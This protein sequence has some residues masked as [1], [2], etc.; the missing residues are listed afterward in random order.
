[1]LHSLGKS[2]ILIVTPMKASALKYFIVSLLASLVSIIIILMPFHALLTVY[3]SSL[4]GHYTLLRLW[5]EMLL[6][7]C[8]VGCLYLL[9]A[10][11]KVRSHTLTRR[12]IWVIGGYGLWLGVRVLLALLSHDVTHKA[13]AYGLLIDL[14]FLAFF[15]VAWTVALRTVQL[16]AQWQRLLLWP[17]Y[18]VVGFALLQ[19]LVL[20]PDFLRHFGYD[21]ATTISPLETINHNKQ[22]V[23]VAS[24]LRGANPL[25]AYLLLPISLLMVYVVTPAKRNRSHWLVLVAALAA[26]FF[27]FS[28]SAWLGAV[29]SIVV[30]LYVRFRQ[31]LT[32]KLLPIAL[33]LAVLLVGSAISLRHNPRFENVFLHTQ[34]H[35]TSAKS[36]NQGH[37]SA[38]KD[39]VRDLWHQPFGRGPGTAGPASVYNNGHA[40]LAENY[41]VQVGQEAGWLGLGLFIVIN[42]GVGYLLWLRRAEP[43]ALSLFAGLIGL[44]FVNL[45]SH[46]WADDTLAYVWWGL[47]GIA[48]AQPALAAKALIPRP[49]KVLANKHGKKV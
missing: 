16:P 33:V 45:L 17:A 5:K 24:T 14:R 36:S 7:V 35:S 39:G 13:A 26:L 19:V 9:M 18:G 28:R 1:M 15:L 4:L 40:R 38:L 6:F 48:M 20:P 29:L 27:T 49:A 32:T 12:L 46:A 3:G 42:L 23:R 41:F 34:D 43:L 25:G 10:D 11:T 2:Y 8:I 47:A 44:T 31:S 21:A 37:V 30:V 22:Y